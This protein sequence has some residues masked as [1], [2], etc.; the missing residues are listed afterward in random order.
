VTVAIFVPAGALLLGPLLAVLVWRYTDRNARIL[1]AR[2][3]D[4]R[5]LQRQQGRRSDAEAHA[6]RR[7]VAP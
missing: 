5:R 6:A 1:R 7:G 4:A 2:R 3:R